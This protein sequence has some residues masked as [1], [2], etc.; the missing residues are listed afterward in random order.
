MSHKIPS[1]TLFWMHWAFAPIEGGKPGRNLESQRSTNFKTTPTPNR[2]GSNGIKGVGFV[3]HIFGVCMPY[4]CGKHLIL[5]DFYAIQTPIYMPYFFHI[6][7]F[8]GGGGGIFF[9][10]MGGGD[11]QNCF[12]K[13]MRNTVCV[14][15]V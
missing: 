13:G 5:A 3:C 4:F 15:C 6:F 9:A 12:Q 11:C 14:V 8:L 7:C 2:N 1:F 10:N